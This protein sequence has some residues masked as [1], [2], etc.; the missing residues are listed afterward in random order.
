M[1]KNLLD[2]T[3]WLKI[4]ERVWWRQEDRREVGCRRTRFRILLY[5]GRDPRDNCE[6]MS[7]GRSEAMLLVPSEFH[8][9]S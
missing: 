6:Q 2:P 5:R 8:S 4:S 7:R 9:V 3:L 1:K